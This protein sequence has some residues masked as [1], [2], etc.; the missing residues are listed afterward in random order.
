MVL[1]TYYNERGKIMPLIRRN[2]G[3]TEEDW[4]IY[5][6]IAKKKGIATAT[7]IRMILLQNPE[8]I[9]HIKKEKT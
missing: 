9:E 6:E 8:Y 3:L 1:Y 4:R 7:Y 2:V 5:N